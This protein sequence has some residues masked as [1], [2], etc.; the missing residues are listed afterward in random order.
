MLPGLAGGTALSRPQLARLLG[1]TGDEAGRWE[2]ELLSA[3]FLARDGGGE[4]GFWLAVPGLGALQRHLRGGRAEVLASLRRAPHRQ[5]LARALEA[6]RCRS[7]LGLRYLLRDLVGSGAV[8]ELEAP[9]G[10]AYRLR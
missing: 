9:A 5:A 3:G 2:A 10:R 4:G 8:D 1:G 7:A 6:K